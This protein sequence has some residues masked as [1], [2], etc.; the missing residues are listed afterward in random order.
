MF[1]NLMVLSVFLIP[2][3]A[4]AQ[5]EVDA[6]TKR[7][8]SKAINQMGAQ[9]RGE[10]A[11]EAQLE[12]LEDFCSDLSEKYKRR[13]EKEESTDDAVLRDK[14]KQLKA[15]SKSEDQ[16]TAAALQG[17]LDARMPF[18]KHEC[19]VQS[20]A[21]QNKKM[22][23]DA[24]AT[25]LKLAAK[26]CDALVAKTVRSNQTHASNDQKSSEVQMKSGS[27]DCRA[28]NPPPPDSVS[29]DPMN[30]QSCEI[31]TVELK[32]KPVKSAN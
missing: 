7:E 5:T 9:D 13:V 10:A 26:T 32:V 20:A 1:K 4:F 25:C 19:T 11:Q 22:W 17:S 14:I 31:D 30:C 29:T 27:A 28:C 23:D 3:L 24:G 12:N 2:A 21:D 16:Q 18:S 8:I 15:S 6:K